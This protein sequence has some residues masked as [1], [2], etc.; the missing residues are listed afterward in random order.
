M[1]PNLITAIAFVGGV[2]LAVQSA[3]SAQLGSIL[4]NPIMASISTYSSGVLFAIVFV[5]FFREE[6]ISWQAVK[7][8]PWYLW[9]IGGLFSIAGI[10]LY[11]F[12]IPKI[13]LGSV[14]VFGLCG[15]LFFA[16]VAGHFGWFNLPLEPITIKRVVGI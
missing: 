15:Q 1:T 13:G 4:K 12:T 11:Y 9:F 2:C 14:M 16:V 8:V 3:F 6:V 10:T 7:Q 5:L